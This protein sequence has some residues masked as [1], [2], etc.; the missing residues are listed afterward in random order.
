MAIW[1][2]RLKKARE[3]MELSLGEAVKLLNQQHKIK[4]HRVN[5]YKLENAETDIPVTK[6]KALCQIY[7]VNPAWVLDY[8]E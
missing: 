4:M 2:K 1:H 6:F 5:L 8:K 7:S 3:S